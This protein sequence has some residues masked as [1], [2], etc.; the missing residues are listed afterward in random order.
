MTDAASRIDRLRRIAA[1]LGGAD[2]EWFVT[3]LQEYEAGARYGGSLDQALG[4]RLGP[5]TTPWW[6][7]EDCGKRDALLRDIA[8]RHF[9]GTTPRAAALAITTA[10]HRY[11]A[12]GW[13]RHQTFTSPPAELLGTLRSDLFVLLKIGQRLSF[14]IIYTALRRAPENEVSG[15]TDPDTLQTDASEECHASR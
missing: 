13:R 6:Q 9:D 3:A 4:L 15:H 2:G 7:I 5:G 14:K 11:A 12:A 10:V 8:A 1:R